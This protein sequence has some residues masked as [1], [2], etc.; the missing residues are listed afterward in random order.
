[1]GNGAGVHFYAIKG[2]WS[3]FLF[4]KRNFCNPK[5]CRGRALFLSRGRNLYFNPKSVVDWLQEKKRVWPKGFLCIVYPPPLGRHFL[6]LT[7][8]CTL[9]VV[10]SYHKKRGANEAFF[11]GVDALPMV[12]ERSMHHSRRHFGLCP[13]MLFFWLLLRF[14]CVSHF[15]PQPNFW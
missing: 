13:S 2:S 1:M 14:F 8:F 11:S 12:V 3:A 15:F 5:S 6:R 10:D 9:L 7:F 4:H